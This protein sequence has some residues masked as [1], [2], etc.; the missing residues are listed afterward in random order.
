MIKLGKAL[1]TD[2]RMKFDSKATGYD[3]I[4]VGLEMETLKGS[5]TFKVKNLE[6]SFQKETL[7]GKFLKIEPIIRHNYIKFL[8]SNATSVKVLFGEYFDNEYFFNTKNLRITT[9]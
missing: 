4:T 3:E 6:K 5:I 7:L 1:V 9:R 8:L 2:F